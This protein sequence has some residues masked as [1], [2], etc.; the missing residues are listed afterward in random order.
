LGV[1]EAS[2]DGVD[3]LVK[4]ATEEIGEVRVDG[5]EEGELGE[6]EEGVGEVANG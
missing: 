3:R 1:S 6:D 2:I 4:E 5:D